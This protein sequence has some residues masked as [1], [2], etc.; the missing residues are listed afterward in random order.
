MA[1]P[2]P[3]RLKKILFAATIPILWVI[4]F[5]VIELGLTLAGVGYPGRLFVS[6]DEGILV[7]N[8][9]YI[10]RF[11][12]V[13][14]PPPF[15]EKSNLL[16]EEKSPGR[17]RVFVVG[18]STAQGFPYKRNHSYTAMSQA[19]LRSAGL[20]VEIVNL[21]N[22]AMSSYYVRDVLRELPRYEP[23]MVVV[24]AGHNEYYGTPSS[25]SGG[26]EFSRNVLLRLKKLRTV[27]LLGSLIRKVSTASKANDTSLMERRFSEA[28][29]PPDP[30]RDSAVAELF[31][32]NLDSGLR[33]LLDEGV[34]VSVFEP[35]S[36]LI[37]MPPFRGLEADSGGGAGAASDPV[38]LY[39]A[40]REQLD[41]GVWDR[42]SWEMA[43]DADLV[44][45]RA[46]TRLIERLRSYVQ[47]KPSIR[48][49]ATADELEESAGPD[50]FTGSYFIDHLHFNFDGQRLLAGMLANAV[51]EQLFPGDPSLAQ[52]VKAYLENI[53]QVRND[54]HFTAFWE[55][56]AYTRIL[57]LEQQEPF[58]SMPIPVEKLRYPDYVQT[59]PLFLT[60]DYVAQIQSEPISEYF[61]IALDEYARLGY[62]DEWLRNMNSY[63][64]L[65]PGQPEAHLAYGTAMLE[66]NPREYLE[67]A[68]GYFRKAWLLS[69]RDPEIRE[70]IR[71]TIYDAGM[72]AAWDAFQLRYLY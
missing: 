29:F 70:Q 69:E 15:I 24:Y 10:R 17:K 64:H 47:E 44:P 35:V 7:D 56:E 33:P 45:F 43:R 14:D 46:R 30:A 11:Y 61:Y 1:D 58:R 52:T 63:I 8:R 67:P 38:E 41:G 26:N 54:I 34:T 55:F 25:L 2:R 42:R 21:G 19:A 49:I 18:G 57:A 36:N 27:Q 13:T 6:P 51:I 20:N 53:D 68:G 60:P 31:V 65:Y 72:G 62:Q 50:A 4:V 22:S 23:D 16:E 28:L 71:E 3:P 39:R 48:W 32:R 66:A 5:A 37:G 9:D 40:A 59:N 12:P